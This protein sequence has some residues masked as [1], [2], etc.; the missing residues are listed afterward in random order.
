MLSEEMSSSRSMPMYLLADGD[1][2]YDAEALPKFV[3]RLV[4]GN[5]DMDSWRTCAGQSAES[6]RICGPPLGETGLHQLVQSNWLFRKR[7]W[8]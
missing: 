4:D 8:R 3:Q 1:D 7:W 2:T 6:V 5:F